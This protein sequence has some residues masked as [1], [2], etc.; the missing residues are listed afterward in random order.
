MIRLK[1]V[2][3]DALS[4]NVYDGDIMIYNVTANV[5]AIN[6]L[7]SVQIIFAILIFPFGQCS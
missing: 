5:C 3:M 7:K 1:D 4:Y 6:N 2:E